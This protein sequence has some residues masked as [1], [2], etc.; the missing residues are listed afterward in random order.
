MDERD[1]VDENNQ[2][3]PSLPGR[4][5][6]LVQRLIQILRQAADMAASGDQLIGIGEAWEALVALP[7]VNPEVDVGVSL[8]HRCG[9]DSFEESTCCE[10]RVNEDGVE[11]ASMYTRYSSDVGS[12]HESQNH[13]IISAAGVISGDPGSWFELLSEVFSA[14]SVEVTVSRDHV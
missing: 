9:D 8:G 6:D 5:G 14:D 4:A 13:A 2:G 3:P 12:D 10:I 7:E 11:L 1:E